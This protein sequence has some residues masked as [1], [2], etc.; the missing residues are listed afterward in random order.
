M[1]PG[2]PFPHHQERAWR[3]S[4]GWTAPGDTIGQPAVELEAGAKP[5]L[6]ECLAEGEKRRQLDRGVSE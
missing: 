3:R 4:G 2:R 5:Q 1:A 6:A